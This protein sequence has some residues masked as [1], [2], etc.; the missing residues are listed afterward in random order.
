MA[1]DGIPTPDPRQLRFA[2]AALERI[3]RRRVREYEA[4]VATG[5]TRTC[6]VCGY[7]G[8]FAP[9]GEPP[10]LDG[11]CPLCRSRERHR[12]FKLWI[13]RRGGISAEMAVLHFAPEPMFE[14]L[15]RGQAG[16][17][18]TADFMRTKVDRKLNIEA[19]EIEDSSFDLIIAHQILEHVDHHKALA[20]CFRC[21][22]PGGRMVVTTPLIES[23]AVTYQN[24]ALATPRD[25][26]LHFG[27]KDHLRYF[28]R[29]LKD[30]MRA[31]GFTL[32]EFVAVE[33]DVSTYSLTRGETL[34]ELTKPAAAPKKSVKTKTRKG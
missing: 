26:M 18:V 15:L 5:F 13:D 9:V 29:D 6:P 32:H 14:P 7:E 27:Q 21:L 3:R 16:T 24:P 20:E 25:R 33:P 19:L 28:G 4:M 31:A 22:R 30:H 17:Y 12:L 23:W 11:L 10:R 1:T 34:F 8:E 2:K